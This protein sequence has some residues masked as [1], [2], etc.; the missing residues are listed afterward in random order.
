MRDFS[1]DNV[2]ENNFS[3]ECHFCKIIV[4]I[5]NFPKMDMFNHNSNYEYVITL[6]S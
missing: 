3:K 1:E 6:I 5:V 4:Y 2:F